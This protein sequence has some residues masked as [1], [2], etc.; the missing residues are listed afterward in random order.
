MWWRAF[1]RHATLCA[2]ERGGGPGCINRSG[3]ARCLLRREHRSGVSWRTTS[4]AEPWR[5]VVPW[6]NPS[7][8]PI[9][10][11]SESS[12]GRRT[13]HAPTDWATRGEGPKGPSSL[14]FWI[15][16]VWMRALYDPIRTAVARPVGG[17]GE[18]VGRT[19]SESSG[20]GDA[21]GDSP[22]AGRK[23]W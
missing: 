21:V 6:R 23:N 11:G 1:V 13:D 3:L 18:A 10:A 4:N 2:R 12:A 15:C 17:Y 20:A 9:P 5:R 19:G 8:T 14:Y 22:G 16:V 7:R